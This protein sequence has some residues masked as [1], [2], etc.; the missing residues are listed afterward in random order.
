MSSEVLDMRNSNLEPGHVDILII[1]N[2]MPIVAK[3]WVSEYL[4][5][6][7]KK[8]TKNRKLVGHDIFPE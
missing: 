7:W 5:N 3:F 2:S 4:L 6:R 8:G 1:I